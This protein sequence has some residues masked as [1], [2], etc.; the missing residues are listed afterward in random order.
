MTQLAFFLEEPSARALLEGLL[1][2]LLPADWF[3]KYVVFEGKKDLEKQLVPRLRRWIA[4]DTRFVVLRDQDAEDCRAVKARVQGLVSKTPHDA[5]VRIACRDLESW[6][7]G[8]LQALGTAFDRPGIAQLATRERYRA[9]DSLVRPYLELQKLVPEYQKIDGA[10]R[11][12]PLLD[13]KRSQSPSFRAFCE[14]LGGLVGR[15]A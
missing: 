4:P 14:G 15:G 11:V 12:G 1:P 13:A 10:R 8:D 6:V 3:P 7:L 2:R 5:L 9:P